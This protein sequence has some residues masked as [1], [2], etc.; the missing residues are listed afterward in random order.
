MPRTNLSSQ[1]DATQR[2]AFKPKIVKRNTFQFT[3]DGETVIRLHGTDIVRKLA[4]GSVI[5]NSGGWKTPTTKDRMN[6][7]MPD[8][9]MINQDGGAW[10]VG[11]GW[12]DENRVP[13]F[14]G[15]NVPRDVKAPKAKGAKQL[16]RE[17][18]LQKQIRK[19]VCDVPMQGDLPQPDNGDCWY[20]RMVTQNGETLGDAI[21]DNDHI[22]S[23]IKERYMHGSLIWN[24]LKWGGYRSPEFMFQ[25]GPRASIRRA[26]KRYL[27]RQC[28][29][30]S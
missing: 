20:C 23:H 16:A 7:H 14:D 12:R 29:L 21:G 24:A 3:R 8:G 1:F 28:K 11:K 22:L 6:D 13:Y 4:N 9:F 25:H 2:A 26:L 18:A 30:V 19:F 17:E 5:L 10:Y 15:M 27:Y